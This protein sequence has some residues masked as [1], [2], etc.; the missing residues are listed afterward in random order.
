MNSYTDE[1][2]L[3]HAQWQQGETKKI[4]LA[5]L[6]ERACLQTQIEEFLAY[7]EVRAY[8]LIILSDTKYDQGYD[9]ISAGY[10]QA[11]KAIREEIDSALAKKGDV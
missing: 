5:L 8:E 11:A 4:I 3:E 1:Q 6:A 7:M 10:F 9:D 2:V